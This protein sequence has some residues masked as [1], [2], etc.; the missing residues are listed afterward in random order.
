M[1]IRIYIDYEKDIAIIKKRKAINIFVIEN[2]FFQRKL[3]IRKLHIDIWDNSWVI[4]ILGL[5]K[6]GQLGWF[7][8]STSLSSSS[9]EK[10]RMVQIK[11]QEGF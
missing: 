1:I 10:Y 6:V 8:A 2:I 5:K 11:D 9:L 4:I 3:H 7:R